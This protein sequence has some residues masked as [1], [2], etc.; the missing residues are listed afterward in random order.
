MEDPFRPTRTADRLGRNCA[1]TG[2]T[3]T[4]CTNAQTSWEVTDCNY[5]QTGWEV[6]GRNYAL[7]GKGA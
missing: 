5:A 6:T 2:W 3:V 1:E 4:G 7:H